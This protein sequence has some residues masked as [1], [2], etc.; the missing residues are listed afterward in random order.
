M[1]LKPLSGLIAGAHQIFCHFLHLSSS[2]SVSVSYLTVLNATPQFWLKT[3]FIFGIKS[4]FK[5]HSSAKIVTTTVLSRFE[6]GMRLSGD[7]VR[8]LN[9]L[10]WRPVQV[11]VQPVRVRTDIQRKAL[12]LSS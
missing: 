2:V 10:Y 6:F 5:V 12:K 1:P 8:M 11:G 4:K 7:L 9:Q 3:Q